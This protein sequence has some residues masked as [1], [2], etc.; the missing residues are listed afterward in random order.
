MMCDLNDL[1]MQ[2]TVELVLLCYLVSPQYCKETLGQLEVMA[3]ELARN[4]N[5][6][7]L[8]QKPAEVQGQKPDGG[9]SQMQRKLLEILEALEWFQMDNDQNSGMSWD[10]EWD[11]QNILIQTQ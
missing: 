7:F 5:L 3:R 1:L 11:V 8:L 9:G 6:E 4:N 2:K 10:W